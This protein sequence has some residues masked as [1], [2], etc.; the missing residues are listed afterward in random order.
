M[1]VKD[2][3]SDHFKIA[4]A[5]HALEKSLISYAENHTQLFSHL[6][7]KILT[8]KLYDESKDLHHLFIDLDQLRAYSI[9]S[10]LITLTGLRWIGANL[11]VTGPYGDVE[12]FN[13]KNFLPFLRSLEQ[14][15]SIAQLSYVNNQLYL[16]M[17]IGEEKDIKG[18]LLLP[19]YLED[20]NSQLSFIK[21]S[22]LQIT[23][24]IELPSTAITFDELMKEPFSFFKIHKNISWSLYFA[25]N[26]VAYVIFF[27]FALSLL[28]LK[29][30][31]ESQ[32]ASKLAQS[33]KR[34]LSLNESLIA[35]QKTANF[36]VTRL[37]DGVTSI[38][39]ISKFLL[40]TK[41]QSPSNV[42]SE[43]E[44]VNFVK[45]IYE[46]SVTLEK[47]I[48]KKKAY[49]PV[50]IP[51]I[52]NQCLN[53]NSYKIDKDSIQIIREY[54]SIKTSF[55]S[56]KESFYQLMLNLFHQALE[57]TPET[58]SILIE[59]KES[60]GVKDC[61][62][63]LTIEDNGYPFSQEELTSFK[64]Q[65]HSLFESYFDLEWKNILR[66]AQELKIKISFEN[67]APLG[68]RITLHIYEYKIS[69]EEPSCG[70]NI[71]R[72]FPSS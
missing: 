60:K 66:L 8:E 13:P 30:K 46:T 53:F 11:R 59:M 38:H 39:E 36:I 68:N 70:D 1:F 52:I 3:I 51:E 71:I 34:I 63:I 45:K 35:Q 61:S 67:L 40:E 58:G 14:L 55:T 17:G 42:F 29:K 4:K 48:I 44:Y 47:P 31:K 65:N 54:S 9:S 16:G 22:L 56:D 50:D 49:E 20:I 72:L 6:K 5:Q 12:N 19:I 25:E 28:I 23:S 33:Q 18:Y 37:H 24:K 69:K 7:D 27:L 32:T 43:K 10:S 2:Y 26:F 41:T 21:P 57:R 64:K 15:P 62:Y